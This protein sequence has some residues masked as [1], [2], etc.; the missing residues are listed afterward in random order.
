[1][2]ISLVTFERF[3]FVLLYAILIRLHSGFY[4]NAHIY[5]TSMHISITSHQIVA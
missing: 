3:Y 2:A 5:I 4:G 1:M